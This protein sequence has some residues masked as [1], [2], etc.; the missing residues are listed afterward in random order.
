MHAAPFRPDDGD[1]P[2]AFCD[3]S[4]RCRSAGGVYLMAA[5]VLPARALAPVRETL[6][7]ALLPGQ[8]KLHWRSESRARRRTLTAQVTA[9]A[10]EIVVAT[11]CRMENRRQERARRKALEIL[12]AAV[13]ERGVTRVVL[14]SRG[15]VRDRSDTSGLH[16][17]RRAGVLPSALRVE[18]LPG[19]EEPA[20]WSADIAVGAFGTALDG[21]P[22]HWSALSAGAKTSVLGCGQCGAAHDP[23]SA[24]WPHGR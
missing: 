11:A 17:L 6:L 8:R 3:E 7:S 19:P 4:L 14:E 20:L 18:H 15:S 22:A 1:E 24:A 13:A 12:L 10:P 16:G 21:D 9:S 5:V 2:T 23:C